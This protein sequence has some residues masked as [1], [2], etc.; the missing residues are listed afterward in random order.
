MHAGTPI[1][2]EINKKLEFVE[3]LISRNCKANRIKLVQLKLSTLVHVKRRPVKE[4]SSD[5][6]NLKPQSKSALAL[7]LK[8]LYF[9]LIYSKILC[10]IYGKFLRWFI[11]NFCGIWTNRKLTSHQEHILR[12]PFA[13]KAGI[14]MANE[15]YLVNANSPW[16]AIIKHLYIVKYALL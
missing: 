8:R 14:F 15:L 16:A 9:F 5:K 7:T 3:V 10:Q 4:F 12:R 13:R 6:W 1:L 11:Q 2:D